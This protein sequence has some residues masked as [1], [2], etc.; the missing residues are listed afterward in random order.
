[1]VFDSSVLE[2]FSVGPNNSLIGELTQKMIKN[3]AECSDGSVSDHCK[4]I[5]SSSSPDL[6]ACN[7]AS[8]SSSDRPA[9]EF[10]RNADEFLRL[11]KW[12]VDDLSFLVGSDL[13]IFGT[14]LH[15][16]ISLRLSPLHKP[17]NVLTGIDIWLENILNEV[18]E[19]AMCFHNEGIVMQEYE[20]Y[21]TTDLP[22][23]TGFDKDRILRI[24]RNLAL[25]LKNNATQE[26]HTYWLV[27][28]PGFDVVKL[29][30]LTVLCEKSDTSNAYHD[31]ES[32]KEETGS[33]NPFILPVATLC[34]KLAEHRVSQRDRYLERQAT[35]PSVAGRTRKSGAGRQEGM[36]DYF[37]DLRAFLTDV[38]RLLKNCLN[39]IGTM[40]EGA[41]EACERSQALPGSRSSSPDR[42]PSL[43]PYADLKSRALLLLCRLYLSTPPDDIMACASLV[44]KPTPAAPEMVSVN[45]AEFATESGVTPDVM[46][47]VYPPTTTRSPPPQVS[48]G[49]GQASS[50]KSSKRLTQRLGDSI[51]EAFRSPQTDRVSILAT[52]LTETLRP[53]LPYVELGLDL[54]GSGDGG[55]GT[56]ADAFAVVAVGAG[57]GAERWKRWCAQATE[58]LPLVVVK[59]AVVQACRL[60][61][62]VFP[63]GGTPDTMTPAKCRRL[64]ECSQLAVCALFHIE[65]LAPKGSCRF[66]G[67]QAVSPGDGTLSICQLGV[68]VRRFFVH[69]VLGLQ[70][71]RSRG[72]SLQPVPNAV[73]KVSERSLLGLTLARVC[74][75]A[76]QLLLPVLRVI[77]IGPSGSEHTHS[78]PTACILNTW[79]G[80]LDLVVDCLDQLLPLAFSTAATVVAIDDTA[81]LLPDTSLPSYLSFT[82]NE[83]MLALRIYVA[84]FPDMQPDSD[85]TQDFK[86]WLKCYLHLLSTPILKEC[87]QHLPD[88]LQLLIYS[89]RFQSIK[90]AAV[91]APEILQPPKAI[92]EIDGHPLPPILQHLGMAIEALAPSFS[93]LSD[94]DL[95]SSQT[96]L[97]PLVKLILDV[98]R[99]AN[100]YFVYGLKELAATQ[101]KVE[102]LMPFQFNNLLST[103]LLQLGASSARR[104]AA[105]GEICYRLL[106][107]YLSPL[108]VRMIISFR[109]HMVRI[110]VLSK[111]LANTHHSGRF[112]TTIT[113]QLKASLTW[114]QR[115][116]SI[117]GGCGDADYDDAQLKYEDY[118]LI[119][120]IVTNM[121]LIRSGQKDV[122]SESGIQHILRDTVTLRHVV[123]ALHD[124]L[125]KAETG[126]SIELL[127]EELL[128]SLSQLGKTLHSLCLSLHSKVCEPSVKY[129]RRVRKRTSDGGKR[130]HEALNALC[131]ATQLPD[132]SENSDPHRNLLIWTRLIQTQLIAIEIYLNPR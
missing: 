94:T 18:P 115:H 75:K 117:C 6:A 55:G 53:T 69:L 24:M 8:T 33:V 13:A 81:R 120:S 20:L 21:N 128:P 28:E 38:L 60:W 57:E 26:G 65:H 107:G 88:S 7:V 59:Q 125:V 62:R 73:V 80:T 84:N 49:C 105:S 132:S 12:R 114:L 37:T 123:D 52:Q 93:V 42:P 41:G 122:L 54:G 108:D 30:D 72:A 110:S 111:Q 27:K 95:R 119:I 85:V 127:S 68:S 96:D 78:D 102:K 11:A 43:R 25:F 48:S 67:Q 101:L 112:V 71:A 44:L 74:P 100:E 76:S 46:D 130:S 29:Y 83:F 90:V 58:M 45:V 116:L 10:H 31:F 66:C 2:A 34:F 50:L 126:L 89:L 3:G 82:L 36:D 16:C 129:A 77:T 109:L 15:P 35:N 9:S 131:V 63:P 39:L 118:R 40:E 1:M 5:V 19:V 47:A 97:G 98:L 86:K 113:E 17:I 87:L 32:D 106:H 99:T 51:I 92:A 124:Y 64:H 121:V 104:K 70:E 22:K 56:K 23:L 103:D 14:K 91:K 79:L 61:S 4:A